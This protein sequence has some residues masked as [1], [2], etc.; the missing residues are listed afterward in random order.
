[1]NCKDC[2]Q[3]AIGIV[4]TKGSE[5]VPTCKKCARAPKYAGWD[6]QSLNTAAS[7]TGLM[8]RNMVKGVK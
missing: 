2:G 4:F 1:M 6:S 5:D 8:I 3:P 7:A